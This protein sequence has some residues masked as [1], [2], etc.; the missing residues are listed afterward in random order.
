MK[1]VLGLDTSCYT[2]SVAAVDW[3]GGIVASCRKLLEVPAKSRG[4]QQ[5]QAGFFHVRALPGLMAE[6]RKAAPSLEICA[7]C[8]STRPRAADDSYMPVFCVGES[9]GRSIASLLGVSFYASDHQS[10]HLHAA[11]VDTG[12]SMHE[13]FL[14]LHLSGGTTELLHKQGQEVRCLGGTADIS[15][16]QLVDRV[17]V[18]LGLPF[19]SGPLLEQLALSGKAEQLLGVSVQ[20]QGEAVNCHLSGAEAQA[21]RWIAAGTHSPERIAAEVFG[22]LARTIARMIALG[23]ERTGLG[24]VLLAGGVASSQHFGTLLADRLRRRG[25]EVRLHFARPDLAGDNAVGAALI[26]LERLRE[27]TSE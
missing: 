24:D 27:T 2:T 4:L 11:L 26:G 10:G 8:A 3:E 7:V 19:P 1:A 6:L 20:A 17:G 18:A 12:L 15:A 5:S 13:D 9:Q 14:A 25:P 16:G 21:M 22:V 23:V